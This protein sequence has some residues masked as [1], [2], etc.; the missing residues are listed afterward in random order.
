VLLASVPFGALIFF[1]AWRW[2]EK[3]TRP[4]VIARIERYTAQASAATA[5]T[6][7]ETGSGMRRMAGPIIRI[8]ETML[9]KS[10]F[11]DR[12]RFRAEQAAI[13]IKPAELFAAMVVFAGTGLLL[14]LMFGNILLLIGLPILLGF[15]PNFWLRMK[16]RKR[17]NAFEDQLADVLG[18][19]ASSLKAG[20]SFNQALNAMIKD[21]PN[22]TAEEFSRVMT[23]SRLGMPI[24]DAL[25][26]M[27]DRMGS[28]DFEFAVTTVNI[29]RTVGGSLADILD[30]VGDTVRNRQQFRKKVKAL[31][32]MGQMSAYVLLAMPVF[33]AT[34]ITIMS[35]DYMKPMFTTGTGHILLGAGALSMLLGYFACMKVVNVK[36]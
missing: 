30:M 15:M 31:T 7:E 10:A 12:T 5:V 28:A 21:A 34:V 3:R 23:E 36:V 29:Q 27:A 2:L 19:I 22:P 32:S 14:G 13:A 1:A 4:D 24:E 18:G 35:P 20:H 26:R 33:M 17:R 16:A 9:G 8:G 25:Q 11:F 6:R